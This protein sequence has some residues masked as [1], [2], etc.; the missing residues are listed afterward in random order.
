VADPTHL[1][2][3]QVADRLGLADT[4]AVLAWI[5]AGQL[6]A[7]NVSAGPGRPTWRIAATDL[8][9]FLAGR[10]AVPTPAVRRSRRSRS[11]DVIRF[12]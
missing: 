10:R 3:R 4:D 12:Y 2:T 8:D 5:A 9:T 6:A 1:T 7:V 11:A